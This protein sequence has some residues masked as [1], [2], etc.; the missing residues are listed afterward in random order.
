MARVHIMLASVVVAGW[1]ALVLS[2]CGGGGGASAPPSQYIT[3]TNGKVV[4]EQ[5]AGV[6]II[7]ANQSQLPGVGFD[8]VVEVKLYRGDA[9]D[10]PRTDTPAPADLLRTFRVSRDGTLLDD[11]QLPEGRYTAVAE[12]IHVVQDG[13]EFRSTLTA[14]VFDVFA[15]GGAL[16]TTL[17]TKFEAKFPAL[18]AVIENS[19]VAFLTD[20]GATGGTSRLFVQHANGTV[21]MTRSLREW[22]NAAA[23][24][25]ASVSFEALPGGPALGNVS[26][27]ILKA[28]KP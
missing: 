22:P 23:P 10:N 17:P 13:K 19:Y 24:T 14:Y 16:H 7:K 15:Q 12:N 1:A 28:F 2:G 8:D 25:N 18:G 4:V 3:L 26:R 21:D 9:F 5:G 6:V 11:L 27:L 20:V